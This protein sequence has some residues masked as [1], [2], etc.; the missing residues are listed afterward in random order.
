MIAHQRSMS[1]GRYVFRGLPEGRFTIKVRPF[2]TNLKEGTEDV[3]L[4]NVFST[5][6][7]QIINFR[8]ERDKRFDDI[9]PSVVSTVFAQDV[10][11]E[12]RRLYKS[13]IDNIRTNHDKALSDLADAIR[14]F[15]TYFDAL[16]A[17]GKAYILDGKYEQGYPFLI[18]AINVNG[19][20]GD[21]FYSLALTLYKA[22]Q[23]SDGVRAVNAA[24]MLEPQVPAIRL[25]QGMLLFLNS[26]LAGAEKALLTAKSLFKE[27]D[28]DVYWYLSLIYNK[29]KRN[30]EAAD[31]LEQ[32]LKAK[33]GLSQTEKERIKDLIGKLRKSAESQ[34]L[35]AGKNPQL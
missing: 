17:L 7:T 13:G 27:P 29:T 19:K 6:E 25:L 3:E 30:K 20:C 5:S 2:G 31:S 34:R 28:A 18:K 9:Q 24:T 15:P 4:S 23:I 22:G 32:Y 1:S 12:A 35:E 14:I 8:L 11:D 16:A 26:D 10:P 21:C 33:S